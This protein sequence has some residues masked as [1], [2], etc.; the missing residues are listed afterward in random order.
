MRVLLYNINYA[1]LYFNLKFL[2]VITII[3]GKVQIWIDKSQKVGD[4]R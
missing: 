2:V 4:K 1:A 3:I